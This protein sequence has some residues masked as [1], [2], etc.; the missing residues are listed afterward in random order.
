MSVQTGTLMP[1][2]NVRQPVCSLDRED[3]ED[4]HSR[5]LER[6]D[7]ARTAFRFLCC[8]AATRA[9]HAAASPAGAADCAAFAA[10]REIDRAKVTT[11]LLA[12]GLA[13]IG[14]S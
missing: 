4:V 8:F 12:V 2:R 11:A 10:H 3:S 5:S 6:S 14:A 9:G 13:A 1:S 7:P